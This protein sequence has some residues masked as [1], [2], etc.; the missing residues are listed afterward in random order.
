MWPGGT[1]KVGQSPGPTCPGARCVHP[2]VC[3]P[4]AG[5]QLQT[6]VLGLDV[7]SPR[8]SSWWPVP[9]VFLPQPGAL[10]ARPRFHP[11]TSLWQRPLRGL[12]LTPSH[13]SALSSLAPSPSESLTRPPGA[14]LAQLA[15]TAGLWR[16]S[17]W[18]TLGTG[19]SVVLV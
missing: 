6:A 14:L 17:R 16:V 4:G 9:A 18:A 12:Y 2:Q 5:N 11:S 10:P 8:W 19:P 3:R 1:S 15:E 7:L 13:S